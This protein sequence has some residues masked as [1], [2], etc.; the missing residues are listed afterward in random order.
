M[1][2]ASSN[3]AD[4]EEMLTHCIVSGSAERRP[5][6]DGAGG[7]PEQLR[8]TDNRAPAARTGEDTNTDQ[9]MAGWRG[10]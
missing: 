8:T 4:I 7:R 5:A 6:A 10:R 1:K 9:H 2:F 3:A